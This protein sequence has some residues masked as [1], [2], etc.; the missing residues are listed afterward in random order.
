MEDYSL[1]MG[2]IGLFI[3]LATVMYLSR[4]IDWYAVRTQG[5]VI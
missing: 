3:V 4:K 5:K 1:L 2:S